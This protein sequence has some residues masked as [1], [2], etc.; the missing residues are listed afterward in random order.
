MPNDSDPLLDALIDAYLINE[1]E[2][3]KEIDNIK[4]LTSKL[5]EYGIKLPTIKD[6]CDAV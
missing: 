5:N 2:I 3:G 4:S 1:K 6:G